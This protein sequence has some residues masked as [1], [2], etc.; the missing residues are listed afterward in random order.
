VARQLFEPL[1]ADAAPAD[2]EALLAGAALQGLIALGDDAG[3]ARRG[4]IALGD[5]AGA[6]PS[7][8]V[9]ER[10]FTVVHGLY[11]LVVNASAEGR[12]STA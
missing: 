3:A 8:A 2:E 4:L 1:L 10:L 7:A 11:W 12:W 9:S 6:A 5:D